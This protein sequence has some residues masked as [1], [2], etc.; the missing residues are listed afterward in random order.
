MW[1]FLVFECV[2]EFVLAG[3]TIDLEFIAG[4]PVMASVKPTPTDSFLATSD[5]ITI[6]D[7]SFQNALS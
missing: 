3:A 1:M 5:G 4:Q 2:V 6:G 7:V